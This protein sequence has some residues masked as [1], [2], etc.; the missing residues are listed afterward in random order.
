MPASVSCLAP[1]QACGGQSARWLPEGVGAH[2]ACQPVLVAP[3][4]GPAASAV[5]AQPPFVG[6][7]WLCPALLQ[8][9]GLCPAMLNCE[10]L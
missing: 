3:R 6:S 1:P 5:H 7:R 10:W 9:E 4:R 2:P 8:P